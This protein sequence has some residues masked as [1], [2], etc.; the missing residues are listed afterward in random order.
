M[1]IVEEL[2]PRL[3]DL[4]NGGPLRPQ[5]PAVANPLQPLGTDAGVVTD[6]HVDGPLPDV[7]VVEAGVAVPED[8]R[9]QRVY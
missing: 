7:R 8:V 3:V 6:L 1:S 5:P 9:L 4:L 2:Q